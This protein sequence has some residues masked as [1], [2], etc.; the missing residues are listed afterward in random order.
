[1]CRRFARSDSSNASPLV[2]ALTISEAKILYLLLVIVVAFA[3]T[4]VVT[5]LA[6]VF[7]VNTKIYRCAYFFRRTKKIIIQRIVWVP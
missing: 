1:M 2:V 5:A 3:A 4:F 7:V 6:I